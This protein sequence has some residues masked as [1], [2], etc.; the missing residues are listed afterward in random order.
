M[1]S[2]IAMVVR[3]HFSNVLLAESKPK[4]RSICVIDKDG[5][6]RIPAA[7]ASSA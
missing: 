1:R 3:E 2:S 6:A 4:G 5:N 7:V